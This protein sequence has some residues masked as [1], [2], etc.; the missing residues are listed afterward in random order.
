MAATIIRVSGSGET[1]TREQRLME[2]VRDLSGAPTPAAVEAFN[3]APDSPEPLARVA[4]ALVHLRRTG[5]LRIAAY[6]PPVSARPARPTELVAVPT[7]HEGPQWA[8]GMRG[9]LVRSRSRS[10]TTDS[11]HPTGSAKA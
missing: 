3:Q 6:V 5:S 2:L 4:H 10:A 1:E 9:Q 8:T 11:M 7:L